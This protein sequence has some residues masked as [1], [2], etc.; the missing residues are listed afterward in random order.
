MGWRERMAAW[1]VPP[2]PPAKRMFAG[3]AV[4]RLT[5]DWITRPT[6]IDDKIRQSLRRLR[7][8]SRSL[9][10]DNPHACRFVQLG[11]TNVVGPLG[12][13]LQLRARNARGQLYRSLNA[14]VE[15]AWWDWSRAQYASADGRLTFREICAQVV[16]GW[17]VDGEFLALLRS[18]PD[19]PYRF[20]IK[21]LDPDQLDLDYTEEGKKGR[22][23]VV[24]GVELDSDRRP[25]AYHIWDGH[26]ASPNRGQRRRYPANEV[27]HSYLNRYPGQTRGVPAFAPVLG[28]LRH[29]DGYMEA[30]LVAARSGA[31]KPVYL[32]PGEDAVDLT[33]DASGLPT[34]SAIRQEIEPGMVDILPRGYTVTAL[35]PTHPGGQFGPFTMTILRSVAAGLGVSYTSMTGDLSNANY[36]SA[37]VGLLDE[38]D[39]WRTLQSHLVDQVCQPVFDRWLAMAVAAGRVS[40]PGGKFDTVGRAATW[41]SR[42]WQWVD[43]LKDVQALAQAIALGVASR[44]D[45]CAESGNDFEDVLEKLEAEQ[46]LAAEYGVT[47][48]GGMNGQGQTEPDAD[49]SAADGSAGDVPHDGSGSE[50]GGT[51][52]G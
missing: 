30:E 13:S 8:R 38:R 10:T 19:N 24:M 11:Q 21:V 40:I 34:T 45:A 36:S 49:E 25:V 23:D 31:A 18:R 26:P 35:D 5:E 28:S 51:A 17:F 41:Q 27:L 14:A 48:T 29:L 44:S 46:K 39:H 2:P 37:R 12:V 33:S 32:V 9:E 1:L 47:V 43:P 7:D 6:A 52:A 42:G 16:R 15:E 22:N 20:C 50:P 3:A 4:S